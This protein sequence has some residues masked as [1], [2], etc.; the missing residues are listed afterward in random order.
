MNIV[1]YA[2][3]SS[4]SQNEQS[5]EGQLQACYDYARA[6][7]HIVGAEYIDSAQSGV[8]DSRTEFQKMI[9]D[10]EFFIFLYYKSFSIIFFGGRPLF[11]PVFCREV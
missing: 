4:H 1:I 7:G 2:R 10:R 6:N 11:R 9:T 8:T 5:I 3:C